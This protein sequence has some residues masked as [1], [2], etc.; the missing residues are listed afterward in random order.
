MDE[1]HLILCGWGCFPTSACG[2]QFVFSHREQNWVTKQTD[3]VHFSC[4]FFFSHFPLRGASAPLQCSRALIRPETFQSE[5]VA[6]SS[7]QLLGL[8]TLT[9]WQMQVPLG[10]K[11]I[12]HRVYGVGLK[13]CHEGKDFIHCPLLYP[14]TW[15]RACTPQ[16]P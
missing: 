1:A 11:N 3:L 7:D 16:A 15:S 5:A 10:A 6:L 9:Q 2:F 4:S 8:L 13:A 12:C 14:S